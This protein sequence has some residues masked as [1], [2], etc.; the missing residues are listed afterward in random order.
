MKEIKFEEL[1]LKQKLSFVHNATLNVW[2]DQEDEDYVIELVKKRAIGSV[3][4]QWSAVHPE[5]IRNRIKRIREAADYPI[6]II[7]D[8]ECG[9]DGCKI[10]YPNALARVKSEEYSYAFGKKLGIMAREFGYNVVC[11]PLLDISFGGSNRSFGSDIHEIAKL[12]KAQARGMH[13]AGVLTVGKHYP[14]AIT[15]EAVDTHLVEEHCDQTVENLVS[16]SLYAYSELIKEDLLDGIMSGH[17]VME[18]IDPNRPASLS[19]AVLNVIREKCGFKG[20]IISDA[21][22]MMGIRAKYGP[23]DP[24]GMCIEAGNDLANMYD[25]NGVERLQNA[26]EEC[27]EK[28]LLTEKE[29]DRAVKNVLHAQQK[30]M[31]LDE[32]RATAVTEDEEKL[33]LNIDADGVFATVDEGLTVTIP[34]DGKHMFVIVASHEYMGEQSQVGADT[35]SGNWHRPSLIESKLKELFPNSKTMIMHQYPTQKQCLWAINNTFGYDNVVFITYSEFQAYTGPECFTRRFL[36][37]INSMQ[38]TNRVST[39]IH[40]G[41]PKVMEELPHIGR[42]ILGGC[43][44]K[45]TLACLEVLAG[46]REAK[47]KLPYSVNFK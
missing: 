4:V 33:A 7:T 46:E 29:L 27:Y 39:I 9:F 37:I 40:Y 25:S 19:K 24:M 10:G 38:Y 26:M 16:T 44:Q 21:L 45:S 15:Q 13:D 23:Y 18:K 17:S 34:C 36:N 47:G 20:F 28:G 5:L 32:K 3:W 8:A 30:V 41:N 2:C 11:N 35:F 6:L 43:S 42:K 22:C 1:S 12:A 14:S 31:E